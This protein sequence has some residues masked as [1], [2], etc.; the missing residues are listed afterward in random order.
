M[1]VTPQTIA[2]LGALGGQG[3]SV[4]DTFLEDKSFNVRGV[5]R[6]VDSPAPKAR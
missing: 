2:V 5:T 4:V 6:S 3:G 1:I